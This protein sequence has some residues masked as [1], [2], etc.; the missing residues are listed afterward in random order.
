M[1]RAAEGIDNGLYGLFHT[2]QKFTKA[3]AIPAAAFEAKYIGNINAFAFFDQ[4]L[5]GTFAL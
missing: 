1:L 4:Y 5:T 3:A 2:I